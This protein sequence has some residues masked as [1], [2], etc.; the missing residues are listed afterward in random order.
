MSCGTSGSRHHY[1][2]D[3]NNARCHAT[4]AFNNYKKQ[5]LEYNFQKGSM[6]N[7]RRM[8]LI[9]RGEYVRAEGRYHSGKGSQWRPRDGLHVLPGRI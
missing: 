4:K 7:S 8:V 5:I 6:D 3:Q 1:L 9:Q 2:L